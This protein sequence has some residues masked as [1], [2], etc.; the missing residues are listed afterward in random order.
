MGYINNYIILVVVLL[1]VL[2]LSLSDIV[3]AEHMTKMERVLVD[4]NLDSQWS[5][6]YNVECGT[7]AARPDKSTTVKTSHC[8]CF[9]Y[10]LCDTLGLYIPAPPEFQ[11]FHLADR[12]LDWLG[13]GD[14]IKHGWTKIDEAVP[15]NYISAQKKANAGHI[16]IAGMT[17]DD[18]VNGHVGVVRPYRNVDYDVIARRGPIVMAS[19]SPNTYA[20][21]LDDEFR[22]NDKRFA[23]IAGRIAFYYNE[24]VPE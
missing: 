2:A 6:G 7:G 16:V 19:S 13:S 1:G 5:A 12:Q 15:N 14:G 23:H 9:I 22:L 11:Q 24:T 17:Q 4:F 10:A 3:P 21:Y 8:S 18:R 20:S